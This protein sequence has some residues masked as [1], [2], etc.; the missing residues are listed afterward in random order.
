[1]R[2]NFDFFDLEAFLAV[3]ETGSFHAAADRLGLSQSS[4]TR[5]VRK[6]EEALGTT[7]FERTTRDVRPTLAGKRLQLRA[8]AMLQEARETTRALRDESAAFAHQRAQ[9]VTLATI[10]TVVAALVTPAIRSLQSDIKPVRIRLL[11][12]AANEVAEAV[13]QG[14]ADFGLCSVPMLEPTTEFTP[15]FEEPLVLAVHPNH[16]LAARDQVYWHD[17]RNESLV[18]PAQGTGN[19]LVIYEA[20]ARSGTPIRWSY[21][22]RRTSTA[23][24]LVAQGVAV[25]PVPKLVSLH[26]ANRDIAWKDLAD[27]SVWRPIGLLT[28]L[29]QSHTKAASAFKEKI[30]AAANALQKDLTVRTIP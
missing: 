17:L 24:D 8:D 15:L 21:E 23:L 28:R 10:P 1:M 18:L 30:L 2:I 13:A 5:R 22:A 25:S 20:L 19:R 6:L 11:D 12:L 9:T 29:G 3:K 16:R 27:P 14:E 7:L 4:V 26:T